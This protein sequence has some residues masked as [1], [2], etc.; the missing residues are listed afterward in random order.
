MEWKAII[1]ESCHPC[2]AHRDQGLIP[3]PFPGSCADY[4]HAQDGGFEKPSHWP[5][6]C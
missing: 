2:T 1:T 3:V 5:A 6:N 4:A